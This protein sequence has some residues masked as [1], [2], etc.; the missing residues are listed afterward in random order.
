MKKKSISP[1]VATILLIGLVI[2]IALLVILWGRGY[3]EELA[4]KRGLLA[5][6]QQ[7]CNNVEITA[8]KAECTGGNCTIVLKN[9]RE[10]KVNKFIFR[11]TGQ[12]TGEAFE[13]S[14]SLNSLE[15][16]QYDFQ[17]P[18]DAIKNAKSIDVIPHLQVVPGHYVPCSQQSIKVKVA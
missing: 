12:E 8:V 2:A 17:F 6:K 16:K 3:I 13:S 1:L 18:E 7:Q 10:T 14:K 4:Q 9:K 15:V 5:E 11:I